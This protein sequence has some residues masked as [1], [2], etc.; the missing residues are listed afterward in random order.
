MNRQT[1]YINNLGDMTSPKTDYDVSLHFRE[2]LFER[3]GIEITDEYYRELC[4]VCLDNKFFKVLFLKNCLKKIGYLTIAG[5]KVLCLVRRD[6]DR[7]VGRILTC[8]PYSSAYTDE[9][10]LRFCFGTRT[11]F[12]FAET[13][14]RRFL[15][16]LD[17][18]EKVEKFGLSHVGPLLFNSG[19]YCFPKILIWLYKHGTYDKWVLA[20]KIK[21]IIY[22]KD[23]GV[24]LMVVKKKCL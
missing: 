15:F 16:E 13:C 18:F 5:E 19:D 24:E 9:D 10:I 7:K 22:N 8:Y 20:T 17:L 3:Y 11:I 4:D 14:Y 23:C 21:N 2:R 1:A 6:D 12:R